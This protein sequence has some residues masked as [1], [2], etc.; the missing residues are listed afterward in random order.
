MNL[1]QF[2]QEFGYDTAYYVKTL[3]K[4]E[5]LLRNFVLPENEIPIDSEL[6]A[7][8]KEAVS[9]GIKLTQKQL[10]YGVNLLLSQRQKSI[11]DIS[12]LVYAL[13]HKQESLK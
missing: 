11:A 8:Q 12:D 7:L 2:E 6:A 13:Y 5:Y 10:H 1:S 4:V 3:L 9:E